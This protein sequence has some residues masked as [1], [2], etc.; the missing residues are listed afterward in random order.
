MAL[1][2]PIIGSF[3]GIPIELH[4]TFVLLMLFSLF[5]SLSLFVILA[6]LFA[7]VLLHEM[8]HSYTAKRNNIKVDKIILY[9]LG[10]GSMI[11]SDNI[12]P[13]LE[14]RISLAGPIASFVIGFAFG[15]FTILMPGGYIKLFLQ[16][17]FLL[18]IL[19]AVFNIIPWFPLDGGRVVRGYYRKKYSFLQATKKTVFLSNI[20]TILFILGTLAYV[21]INTSYTFLYKEFIVLIDV[22]VAVFIYSGAKSEMQLAYIRENTKDTPL[23]DVISDNYILFKNRASLKEVYDAVIKYHTNIVLFN[24]NGI[25]KLISKLPAPNFSSSNL[26]FFNSNM[27]DYLESQLITV[28]YN[29]SIYDAFNKMQNNNTTLVGVIK[30]KKLIGIILRQHLDSFISL[31]I[32]NLANVKG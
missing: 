10:G 6:I 25:Y 18:N 8:A 21:A 11:D 20:I 7:C 2:S 22:F 14:F 16:V 32:S 15:V 30:G 1:W 27:P 17:F 9:P 5:I 28:K 12:D 3:K 29:D 23:K 4:W 26:S 31:H 19:L 24:E 13:E